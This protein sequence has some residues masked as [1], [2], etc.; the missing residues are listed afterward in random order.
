MDGADPE[1]LMARIE[2]QVHAS[3]AESLREQVTDKCFKTCVTSPS[4]ALSGRESTCM[5]RCLDRFVDAMNVITT[6]LSE[7]SQ[8]GG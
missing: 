3:I 5:E 8:R 4:K 1:E 6:T 2:E 7:R